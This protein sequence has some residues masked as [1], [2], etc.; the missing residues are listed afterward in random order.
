MNAIQINPLELIEKFARQ[1]QKA[2]ELTG[3]LTAERARAIGTI[4]KETAHFKHLPAA[5]QSFKVISLADAIAIIKSENPR[6]LKQN[7]QMIL[8]QQS[9]AKCLN[10]KKVLCRI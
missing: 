10:Q 7:Q 1:R 9:A 8:L 5:R 3:T 4:K 2:F 6:F